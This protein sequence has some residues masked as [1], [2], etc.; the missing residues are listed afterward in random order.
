MIQITKTPL[1][2][3]LLRA[4]PGGL[5]AVFFDDR[6]RDHPPWMKALGG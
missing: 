6:R 3:L 4:L 2:Q 1:A 5:Q